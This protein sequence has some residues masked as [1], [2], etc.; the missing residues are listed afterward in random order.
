VTRVVISTVRLLEFLEGAGHFWVYMQYAQALQRLGCEVHVLD[1]Y[2]WSDED[3]D[4]ER[5][6][7][8]LDRMASYGLQDRVVVASAN[9][10]GD[11][12]ARSLLEDADLLLNFNYHL[13]PDLVSAARRSAL[14]DIDPG[15]LQFWIDRGFISP[16]TH[17]LYFTIGE[18]VGAQPGPIP[19]C[20][21]RWLRIRPPV[22]LDLWPAVYD[23]EAEAFT[24][25][26]TW[27][28]ERDYVGDPDDYY[29]NTKRT[30]FLELIDLPRETEQPLEVALFLAES[31]DSDKQTLQSHGW[32]VR[33]SRDVAGTPEQYRGYVQGSRGEFSWAK[34]SCVRFQNAWVSDRSLC[35]LASGKPVV[36]QHT[37]PSSFLPDGEGMFRFV[38]PDDAVR[39]FDTINSDYER[40]S[41]CARML[42][43]EYFDADVVVAGML[44]QA[45]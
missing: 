19:D 1:S 42:A 44:E 38:T 16:A 17:D 23:A 4:P 41:R 34:P 28:G 7:E 39:A 25:V 18:T 3:P 9:G 6:R 32:R 20:G 12:R 24:T 10:S 13:R 43:E 36:V 21:L 2:T 33:H 22:S 11:A 26:S 37:G 45:L 30:A 31:D 27:W 15:L 14:V 29:D 8:F 5:L 35:Y 40:Q